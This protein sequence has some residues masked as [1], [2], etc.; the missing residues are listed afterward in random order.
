MKILNA[1]AVVFLLLI[2][3]LYFVSLNDT[4]DTI[5]KMEQ[6]RNTLAIENFNLKQ[7]LEEIDNI[8]QFVIDTQ[9]Q[10]LINQEQL[11]QQYAEKVIK[12]NVTLSEVQSFVFGDPT[13]SNEYSK[14]KYKCVEFTDEFIRNAYLNGIFAC[15][16]YV[17][18]HNSSSSHSLVAIKT[19]DKGVVY[20]EPQNDI[21]FYNI[22]IGDDYCDL[23][24]WD[25]TRIIERIS[26]CFS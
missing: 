20:I 6:E 3:F 17:E 14:E 16:T 23:V 7:D 21:I 15:R 22:D 2:L 4:K 8:K 9:K 5:N 25:C 11:R 1:L 26:S 18:Y 13:D 19:T 10:C 12:K 24:N